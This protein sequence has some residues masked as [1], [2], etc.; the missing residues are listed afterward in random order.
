MK[1]LIVTQRHEMNK[2][3]N[4]KRD[5]LDVRLI[6]FIE[7]IKYKPI[8]IPSAIKNPKKFIFSNKPSAIILSGGGDPRK[9]DLRSKIEFELIKYS[10]K[11]KVPLL[12]ICRGAQALNLFYG[13]KITKIKNHVQNSHFIV[14]KVTRN[15]KIKV[16]SFHNFGIKKKLLSKKMEILGQSLDN[17]VECFKHKKLKQLGIMWHP[18]RYKVFRNFDLD[19]ITKL[20]K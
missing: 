7:E 10:I 15:K 17:N 9:K 1:N 6:N 16:N 13:G 4:E 12:G 11:Y 18:E 20:Y 8:L 3:Y 2:Y 5:C 14:G 19:L